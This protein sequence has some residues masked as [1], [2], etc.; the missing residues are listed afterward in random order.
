M[1]LLKLIVYALLICTGVIGLI[2]FG[3]YLLF[4]LK[5]NFAETR[6]Y[7]D[8]FPDKFKNY[9]DEYHS[10]C[11]GDILIHLYDN[12]DTKRLYNRYTVTI[13]YN[14]LGYIIY[15]DAINIIRVPYPFFK[16]E[17]KWLNNLFRQK[18]ERVKKQEMKE[19]NKLIE[20]MKNN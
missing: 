6:K 4:I 5:T 19:M 8:Q 16:K 11:N 9:T 15:N 13:E 1:A 7:L 10:Y 2:C 12:R 18:Y 3:Y 17:R 20:V 14:L